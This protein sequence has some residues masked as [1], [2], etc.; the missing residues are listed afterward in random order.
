LTQGKVACRH[1]AGF[2]SEERSERVDFT[3]QFLES[4][5]LSFLNV[6]IVTFNPR[7]PCTQAEYYRF[8]SQ[9]MET[10]WTTLKRRGWH[11][12]VLT[13]AESAHK[14]PGTRM[15]SRGFNPGNNSTTHLEN[16]PARRSRGQTSPSMID[17]Q[18]RAKPVACKT[19]FW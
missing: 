1:V 16:Q 10:A 3:L 15:A 13:R 19:P 17:R 4:V 8:D 9:L 5:E 7:R 12:R 18:L 6:I 2:P 14:V 11:V